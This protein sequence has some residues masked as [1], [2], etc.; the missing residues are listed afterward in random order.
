MTQMNQ[1]DPG[2][3]R[4]KSRFRIIPDPILYLGLF[5]ICFFVN[6]WVFLPDHPVD[7][8]YVWYA[9]FR[10]WPDWVRGVC[11]I[12]LA[13]AFTSMSIY[14][15]IP[16]NE[17]MPIFWRRSFYQNTIG[18]CF[19][20]SI[21]VVWYCYA[22]LP[23]GEVF[24]PIISPFTNYV[25]E[26]HTL[27][28]ADFYTTGEGSNP[29]FWPIIGVIILATLFVS[30]RTWFY[31]RRWRRKQTTAMIFA[32]VIIL[33]T[34]L[35]AGDPIPTPPKKV[36]TSVGIYDV[37]SKEDI[38]K[39]TAEEIR[40]LVKMED[41]RSRGAGLW[42]HPVLVYCFEEHSF[43]YTGGKYENAEIKYRMRVPSKIVPGKKYPLVL[44]L[45]GS[46]E[47]GNDNTMSL[48]HLHSILPLLI[49]PEQQDFFL[50]IPQC[51][52][53]D[54]LWKFSDE[55][56]GNLDIALALMQHVIDDN[57][58]DEKRL[59]TFGLS[60]GGYGVW[61][62][63]MKHPDLFAAAV[64]TSCAPP[65]EPWYLKQLLSTPIWSFCSKT[66]GSVN[67]SD[68]YEAR[69]IINDAGGYFKFSHLDQDGHA[70][71]RPAMDEYN[72][73][74]WM[75][76]QKRGGWFNP[77]PER[78]VYQGRSLSNCFFS[79]FL[80]LGLAAGLFAFQ[81]T[82]LCE[83]LHE[84]I[85]DRLYR[86][87][88]E[89][90]EYEDDNDE[91]EDDEPADAFRIL[92]DAS[93]TKKIKAKV[94]GFQGD[95]V[96]IQ[97]PEGKIATV[98]IKH[99][100][101]TDQQLLLELREQTPSPEGFRT[102]TDTTG[103]K[104]ITAK[105]VEI[106]PDGKVR[107]ESETGKTTTV[108]PK[109]FCEADR[110]FLAQIPKPAALPEGFRK[111]SNAAGTQSFVAKFVGFQADD[112]V[113]LQSQAGKT[114]PIP[115]NQL[116]QAEQDFLAQERLRTAPLLDNF[117]TWSDITGI[118]TFTAKLLQ[119]DGDQARLE[120]QD[121]QEITLPIDELSVE[122]QMLLTRRMNKTT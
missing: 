22:S 106:L 94:V 28:L 98:A 9:D 40:E 43:T 69:Q 31:I 92:S 73:F 68:I 1:N 108:D 115:I 48:A 59:S 89:E 76:A 64:P 17:D 66:D 14:M 16:R 25:N 91:E 95:A 112:T 55:N 83:R 103:S 45:H 65:I 53:N 62:L 109:F 11:W 15:L 80:P 100:S 75:I 122:D 41:N 19:A 110:Q 39:F 3:S 107:L 119:I 61:R 2:S 37:Q 120:T 84:R 20:L 10:F 7:A 51:P 56:D 34:V 60:S 78:K 102:W 30:W 82:A 21:P 4:R 52:R 97:S 13:W 63:I 101:E 74:A 47:A 24:A 72:S 71:W 57:P 35:G 54:R 50:L 33:P 32:L 85:A 38:A 114:M 113:L 46:G 44:H 90:E 93:G 27:Q 79:F 86:R 81:R 116:G 70:A 88:E 111:W 23:P 26:N 99:F 104:K 29:L 117:R 5:V 121:G 12:I 36:E 77:P 96:K 18:L 8:F 118:N 42:P 49:G 105:L 58:I 6:L 67:Y 87:D